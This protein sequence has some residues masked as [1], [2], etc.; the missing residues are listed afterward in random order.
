MAMQL[1]NGIDETTTG[2]CAQLIFAPIDESFGDDAPLLPS[3]FRVIP[4]EPKSV[5]CYTFILIFW[6]NSTNLYSS[7]IRS[8]FYDTGWPC[9]IA[10]TGFGFGS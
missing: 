5:G 1:C 9:S 6:L 3:G 8:F 4:L 10:N 2:G 7:I